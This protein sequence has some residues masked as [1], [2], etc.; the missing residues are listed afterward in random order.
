MN[1][2]TIERLSAS[3][4]REIELERYDDE[5]RHSAK[6]ITYNP[7]NRKYIIRKYNNGS[8][9]YYIGVSDVIEAVKRYNCLTLD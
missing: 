7:S 9:D 3:I 4:D 6:I 5:G 2:T 8:L 1:K